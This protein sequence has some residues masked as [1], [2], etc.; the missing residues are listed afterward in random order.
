MV[1]EGNPLMNK[2]FLGLFI[3]DSLIAAHYKDVSLGE[4]YPYLLEMF[5]REYDPLTYTQ[6]IKMTRAILLQIFGATK[7][8]FALNLDSGNVDVSIIHCGI[9]DCA[10]RV[11]NHQMR[12]VVSLLPTPLRK[13]VIKFLHNFHE[14]L[15]MVSWS[16][17]FTPPKKF[18]RIYS[19][20]VQL[21][22][23]RSTQVYI[24]EIAPGK[25]LNYEHSLGL[26]ESIIEYNKIIHKVASKF[27]N[28]IIIDTFDIFQRN[29]ESYLTDDLH[30]T[31]AGQ[32][33]IYSRIQKLESERLSL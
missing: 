28:I 31:K 27:S 19:D 32:N 8:W 23:S 33:Y 25:E 18:E 9:I 4:T 12:A 5:W 13:L 7:D 30:I 16:F 22:I 15:Q 11:L 1:G 14:L 24:V 29:P 6:S 20:L 2:H 26:K 21:V 10:P 17:R 3:G